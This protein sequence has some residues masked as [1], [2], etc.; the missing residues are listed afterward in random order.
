M[1]WPQ[2]E[3]TCSAYGPPVQ[4]RVPGRTAAS[5]SGRV[6]LGYEGKGK[7]VLQTRT[8]SRKPRGS[9]PKTPKMKAL[10]DVDKLPPV[11]SEFS[12][13][14]PEESWWLPTQPPMDV[15]AE[16]PGLGSSPPG[17]QLELHPTAPL[18]FL[19]LSSFPSLSPRLL[20][21]A[22]APSPLALSIG[23]RRL[24]RVVTR[25]PREEIRGERRKREQRRRV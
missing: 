18:S 3:A 4:R 15:S 17:P 19:S 1:K 11:P 13:K 24:H 25:W 22:L 10:K 8:A 2:N 6:W 23:G 7:K 16:Q 21:S 20:S 9:P 14:L 5:V 12:F